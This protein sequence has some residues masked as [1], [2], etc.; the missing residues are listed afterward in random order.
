VNVIKELQAR[1]ERIAFVGDGINDAPALQQA[2]LG[3]AL[4]NASDVARESADI[5]LLKAELAAIPEALGLA[6]ATLRTIKQNLFWAFAYNV[7]AIPLA[8]LGILPPVAAAGAMILSSLSVVANALR[9]Q[10]VK[11]S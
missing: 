3:V 9:L 2:D 10:R 5:V 8:M 7:A 4:M 11:L 1:G 6:R